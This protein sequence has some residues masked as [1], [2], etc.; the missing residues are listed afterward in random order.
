[1]INDL[2][3]PEVVGGQL[4][5]VKAKDD[6]G[7][8][9]DGI[10]DLWQHKHYLLAYF[11]NSNVTAWFLQFLGCIFIVECTYCRLG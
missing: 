2:L 9:G 4:G 10:Q 7:S 1:M 11:M 6:C 8:R 3:D 5:V